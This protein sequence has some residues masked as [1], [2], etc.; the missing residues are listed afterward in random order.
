M[1]LLD[2]AVLNP[3][4]DNYT[5]YAEEEYNKER[6]LDRALVIWHEG[7]CKVLDHIGPQLD[8]VEHVGMLDRYLEQDLE[9][10]A[11]DLAGVLVWEGKLDSETIYDHEGDA[12]TDEWLKGTARLATEEEWRAH[13]DDEWPWDVSLW[14]K[15]TMVDLETSPTPAGPIE[16]RC[17]CDDFCDSP[18][19]AHASLEDIVKW[20]G[21]LGDLSTRD[22]AGSLPHDRLGKWKSAADARMVALA[23]HLTDDEYTKW[24]SESVLP[25]DYLT[26]KS[27]PDGMTI[28]RLANGLRPDPSKPFE[29]ESLVEQYS[30]RAQEA[31]LEMGWSVQF[32]KSLAELWAV[33][34]IEIIKSFMAKHPG[35]TQEQALATVF[36]V[37]EFLEGLLGKVQIQVRYEEK[38]G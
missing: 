32:H 8:Y 31:H 35:F 22:K 13:V 27:R 19:P 4:D 18:C 3:S 37:G 24:A 23:L 21:G 26:R 14:K 15:T 10:C 9:E 12:D 5:S 30:Q 28:S 20:D 7:R 11:G 16:P 34:D 36:R 1:S 33:T 38:E 6:P 2:P 25:A 17:S 29:F